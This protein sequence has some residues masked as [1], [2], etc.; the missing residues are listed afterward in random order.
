MVEVTVRK[1]EPLERALRRFKKKYEK[2]GILKDVKRTA[3]YLKPSEE[4]RIKRSKAKR[5]MQRNA[6]LANAATMTRR[7]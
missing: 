7:H 5:R 3:Y 4:R 6:M 2:A 1:D